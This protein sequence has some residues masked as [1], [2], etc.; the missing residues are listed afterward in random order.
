M[1][2]KTVKFISGERDLYERFKMRQVIGTGNSIVYEI[3]DE[4]GNIECVKEIRLDDK[5]AEFIY[6]KEI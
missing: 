2:N 5:Q 6:R 1:S 4:E 3:I